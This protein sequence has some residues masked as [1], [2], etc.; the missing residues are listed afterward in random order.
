MNILIP[1]SW[2]REYLVTKATAKQIKEYLSL[3]GPSV[4]RINTVGKEIVYDIEVTGNR[5]DSMSVVGIAREA[6]A[7]LPRFG[8]SA[9]LVNDP[10]ETTSKIKNLKLKIEKTLTIKTDPILNPRWTSVVMENV[11]VKPSPQWLKDKL[12]ATGIRSLNNVIDITNYLMRAYGQPAHAFD[13]DAIA[14]KPNHATMTLRASKRGEKLITLDGKSH[15]LPGD[16]IVIEDGKGRL[17]D[18]CGIMGGKNSSITSTTK[19]VILFMQTYDPVRIRKTSMA[20]AHRTEAAGLFEKGLDSQLVL[21]TIHKGIELM[22]EL[23]GGI[24]ASKLYDIY[25]KPYKPHQVSVHR[26]KV[27]IY[28]GTQLAD[29][30]IHAILSTLGFTPTITKDTITVTVP[31][32]RRDVA[33]DV[34]II[35]ELA[36][37]YGYH[38]IQTKLPD[39]EPPVVLPNLQLTWEEE[40]KV[41]LRD[42]GYTELYTYSMISEE[43]MDTFT[44]DK[45]KAYKISNPLTSDWAYMRPSLWPSMLTAI[46]QNINLKPALQLFELSMTYTY[47]PNELPIE[48]PVLIVAWTG[49]KFFEAKGLAQ[50]IFSL[51]GRPLPESPIHDKQKLHNWDDKMRLLLGDYG[52]I[53]EVNPELLTKLEIDQPVT[54]FWVHLDEL[55][56]NAQQNKTFHPIPKY[57]PIVE[58]LAFAVPPNFMVGPVIEALKKIHPLVSG[59]TLLDIYNDTRTFHITYLNP[60]KNLTDEEVT[61]I[62]KKLIACALA[63]GAV[64]KEGSTP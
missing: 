42:W 29:K 4:E 48:T 27:D 23:T 31:S 60:K 53:S 14:D 52:S 43:L 5:P 55:I 57:P 34:D 2:L 12:E 28:M 9:K 51:F 13:F 26:Q 3:C 39:S 62:R 30:E 40:I 33:I 32:F 38:N 10:Y 45:S 6:A 1:D 19:T 25:P 49:H 7:I 21:P 20:L 8:I 54:I 61:P 22:T 47:R 44:L 35:E 46:K 64:F 24:V 50:A 11:T 37:L 16:D 36:R 15:A 18:L 63:F 17:I 59:V 58:D 56:K 41:R